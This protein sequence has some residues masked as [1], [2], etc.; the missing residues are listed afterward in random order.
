M[1]KSARALLGV[2]LSLIALHG[3]AV[4]DPVEPASDPA[5]ARARALM[6]EGAHQMDDR[7]YDKAVESFGEAYRLVPSP[8]VLFNLGI[9][10][11]SVA[12]YADALGALEGFLEGQTD[13][14]AASLA[15]A[16]RHIVDL[17]A[18]VV[19]LEIKSDRPGAELSLDGR[20][21]GFVT[22]DHPLTIDPGPHELR[23]RA[24]NETVEQALTTQPGQSA[25][26]TLTF[27]IAPSATPAAAVV[28]PPLAPA[29]APGLLVTTEPA[30][31]GR[32]PLYRRPWLWV[33]VGG[34]VATV[35]VILAVTLSRTDYPTVDAKVQGP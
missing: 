20:S 34:A 35:A 18:K 33:V 13:A 22:F 5:R 7:Q 24:G 19:T 15:T 11:L 12:R 16:R 17:R 27:A 8:K 4:A 10:Y 28:A 23:A 31:V 2:L 3:V 14:P 21:Y 30:P 25:A 1:S 9:A 26:V 6:Q 29:P 32:R